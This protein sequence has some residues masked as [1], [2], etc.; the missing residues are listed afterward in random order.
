MRRSILLTTSILIG[1]AVAELIVHVLRVVWLEGPI[2]TALTLVIGGVVS[3][4]AGV[5]ASSWVRDT[6]R[7][8]VT[9]LPNKRGYRYSGPLTPDRVQELPKNEASGH[10]EAYEPHALLTDPERNKAHPSQRIEQ[11]FLLEDRFPGQ[12]VRRED[13][14]ADKL[15]PFQRHLVY[16]FGVL[17]VE[18]LG[19]D[20]ED[21]RAEIEYMEPGA[22]EFRQVGALDW[23]DKSV[24]DRI[25]QDSSLV[26][27]LY[28]SPPW[29][30]K[31]ELRNPAVTIRSRKHA[32]LPVC[33]LKLGYPR[34]VL[35]GTEDATSVVAHDLSTGPASFRL[36][37]TF[38]AKGLPHPL[39]RE[40]LVSAAWDDI[41]LTD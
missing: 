19:G 30:L 2:G 39:V 24:V 12:V 11:S 9:A 21:C 1:L 20:A 5:A 8:R 31:A 17:D 38:T 34:T 26:D 3:A 29:H 13:Y 41:R 36:R 35:C 7:L 37:V 33:V 14:S 6:P 28:K 25:I 15:A 27:R 10:I 16:E 23:Y 4:V 22:T 40:Y 32:Y 18:N